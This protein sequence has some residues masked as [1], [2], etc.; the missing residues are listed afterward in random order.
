MD[1]PLFGEPPDEGGDRG[2]G[3]LDKDPRRPDGRPMPL[4]GQHP[5]VG[6]VAVHT[7]REH[8]DHDPDLVALAAEVLARQSVSQLVEDLGEPQRHGQEQRVF[9]AEKLVEAGKPGAEDVELDQNQRQRRE[10]QEQADRQHRRLE[11]PPH[12]GIQP[13]EHPLRIDALEADAKHVGQRA[14]DFLAAALVAAFAELSSLARHADHYQSAAVQL[15]EE[16]LELLQ[17]DFLGRELRLEP[18]LD[19]VQACLAVD[20]LEDGVL[21]LLE[22][23]VVQPHRILDDP[24]ALAEV[25]LPPR[26][27]VLPLV[28]RHFPGGAGNQAV[29]QG[30][31]GGSI[32]GVARVR[33]AWAARSG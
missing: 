17:G 25:A 33:F 5:G 21:L 20:H 7:G 13:I 1:Q 24:V 2:Q 30:G 23:E 27:E 28:D 19:L 14:E 29:S 16:L 9:C 22:A 6:D 15:A 8:Q 12:L 18:L 31:H 3:D 11:Q 32:R 10:G 26:R 4:V